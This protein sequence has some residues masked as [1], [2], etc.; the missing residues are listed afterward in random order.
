[1]YGLL[2][3]F[4]CRNLNRQA[5]I[6]QF[7]DRNGYVELTRIKMLLHDLGVAAVHFRS[8]ID[9]CLRRV[10][11]LGIERIAIG[12]LAVCIVL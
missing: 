6:V 3:F 11:H 8:A 12:I 1:M 2:W 7:P 5:P 10:D 9:D 4:T